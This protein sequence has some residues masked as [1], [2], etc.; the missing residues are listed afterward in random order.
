M[1]DQN[2]LIFIGEILHQQ[3]WRITGKP[4]FYDAL[5]LAN[6]S[7]LP[8]MSTPYQSILQDNN[9]N[10]SIHFCDYNFQLTYQGK[11]LQI[12]NADRDLTEEEVFN[13]FNNFVFKDGEKVSILRIFPYGKN[14]P[15]KRKRAR[16]LAVST[17]LDAE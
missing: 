1:N 4:S 11:S 6:Q 13:V 10:V 12:L 3:K 8:T 17:G 9:T 16:V 14:R 15:R 7:P 2:S 5:L